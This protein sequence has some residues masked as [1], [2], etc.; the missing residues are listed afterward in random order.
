[1]S[2]QTAR[3][4]V[5]E[6]LHRLGG[7][8]E[9]SVLV[10][11]TS[12]RRVEHAI[13]LGD[14]LQVSRGRCALPTADA[15]LRRAASVR[16]VV[17]HRSAATWWGWELKLQPPVPEVTVRRGSR[18][19]GSRAGLHVVDLHRDD[20]R[21]DLVTSPSRTVVDC[22]R[23]LPEDEGFAIAD[24]ALRH[25]A[26]GPSGLIALAA[27]V[28]GPGAPRVRR[29]AAAARAEAANPFESVLRWLALEAGLD[30]QPQL[31]ISH[32]SESVRPDLVD[33][34]RRLVLEADSFAWHGG[35]AALRRDCQRYNWLVRHGWI[36]LR[37]AYEDVMHDPAYVLDLLAALRSPV[38][39]EVADRGLWTA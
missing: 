13:A 29:V 1:M 24:S 18:T 33:L 12:R 35:R 14:V 5:A 7:V 22:L 28:R 9:R 27:S 32:G 34:E 4:S 3:V 37:F 25:G 31:R 26:F 30:V 15:A 17:S 16:G 19:T 38:H 10:A 36:V 23:S 39:P 21:D 2:S 8:A 6:H 20:V 11:L